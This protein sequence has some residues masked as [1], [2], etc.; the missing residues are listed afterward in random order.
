M[1][2]NNAKDPE[3]L[4]IL[5]NLL[6]LL[7]RDDGPEVAWFLRDMTRRTDIEDEL[8]VLQVAHLRLWC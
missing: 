7:W 8:R 1:N 2:A 5:G 3:Y 4:E 6:L